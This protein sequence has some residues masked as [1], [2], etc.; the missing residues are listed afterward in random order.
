MFFF[1]GGGHAKFL[2][3]GTLELR[4]NTCLGGGGLGIFWSRMLTTLG[5]TAPSSGSTT[6]MIFT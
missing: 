4:L 2:L 6:A 1:W 5:L 3:R